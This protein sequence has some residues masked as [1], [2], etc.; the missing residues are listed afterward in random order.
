MK[1][2]TRSCFEMLPT[3][4]IWRLPAVVVPL[5]F[6]NGGRENGLHEFVGHGLRGAGSVVG[7]KFPDLTDCL[8]CGGEQ[9]FVER[10]MDVDHV[11]EFAD[12]VLQ[13]HQ[14]HDLMQQRGGFR[15]NEMA[16]E[17]RVVGRGNEEFDPGIVDAHG[18]G[19]GTGQPFFEHGD[20]RRAGRLELLFCE[21]DGCNFRMG[22]H[23]A[24]GEAF[25]DGIG[26]ALEKLLSQVVD[27]ERSSMLEHEAADGKEHAPGGEGLLFTVDL[28][29]GGELRAVP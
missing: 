27:F 12:I 22:E 19:A 20:I 16:A 4:I 28:K 8:D 21:A 10:G 13:T 18:L 2:A 14:H 3:L 23:P 11:G 25:V 26:G 6:Q 5:R 9:A 1:S 15:S 24:G 29:N 17:Y 7:L